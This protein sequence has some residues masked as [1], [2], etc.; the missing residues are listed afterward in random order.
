MPPLIPFSASA[1]SLSVLIPSAA[2]LPFNHIDFSAGAR[3]A[4]RQTVSIMAH[5]F[6]MSF[7]SSHRR[8]S[9]FFLSSGRRSAASAVLRYSRQIGYSSVARM[10][11]KQ[12]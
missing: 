2:L 10:E 4:L 11:L 3:S 12:T 6:S 8:L 7:T 5:R 1:I 9:F